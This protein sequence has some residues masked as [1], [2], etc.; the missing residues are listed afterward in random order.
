MSTTAM[1]GL[2]A[3][4]V[5]AADFLQSSKIVASTHKTL[6]TQANPGRMLSPIPIRV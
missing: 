2:R 1:H 3:C 4:I 6:Q 5:V